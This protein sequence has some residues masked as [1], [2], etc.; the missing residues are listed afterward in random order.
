MNTKKMYHFL[1]ELD[2]RRIWLFDFNDLRVWFGESNPTIHRGLAQHIVD[3]LIVRVTRG[4]Y[5]NAMPS[6]RP[7]YAREALVRYLRPLE[8][9]YES[10]ESALS[11]YGVISQISTR[12][13]MATTGRNGEFVT[14]FGVIEFTHVSWP[15][16]NLY[17]GIVWDDYRMVWT[18]LP[19]QAYADLSKAK[20]N[21]H[22]VDLEELEDA[23]HDYA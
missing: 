20:R 13:T 22:L 6:S 7:M 15:L 16:E 23:R 18:A 4:L 12:L 14:P 10:F 2:A 3:G 21:L 1:R 8:I 19:D 9:S 17:P 11:G 5:A